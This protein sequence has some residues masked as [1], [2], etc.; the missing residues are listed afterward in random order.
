MKVSYKWLGEQVDLANVTPEELANKLTF[1]GI[2]VES[3]E[4]MSTATGLVIGE[5]ASCEKHPDSDHLHVLLVDEGE[6]YGT[7]QIVCGAPNA[8][9][10]LKVIVARPGAVLP[11][12]TIKE[13]VIRG[14]ESKGMCCSLL[15]LGVEKKHLSEKQIQGIEELSDEAKVGD[16]DVLAYLGLDDA[17][18]DLK[19]LAN[20]SDLYS[21][22]S[23]AKEVST[24]LNRPVREQAYE[25]LTGEKPTISPSSKTELSKKFCLFEAERL[26]I[27]ESPKWLRERLLSS[28]VKSINNIVDIGNYVMLLTG[29]PLNMYDR[30]KLNGKSLDVIDDYEGP[31]SAMDGN[32]YELRKGD[33]LIVSGDEPSCLAGILT[34]EKAMVTEKT[35]NIVVE[36]ASFD[37]PSIRHTASRLG[38]SS[39]SSARFIKGVN[40]KGQEHALE[41]AASLIRE[42]AAPS[43][44][45]NVSSYD[46]LER[47]ETVI[48]FAISYING[49]LGTSFTEEEIVKTLENDHLVIEKGEEGL[50][51][52]VPFYRVDIQGKADLS[53]EVIR[54]LGLDHVVANKDIPLGHGGFTKA[55]E[56]VIAI[57]RH[58]RAVGLDECLTYSLVNKET[59]NGFRYFGNGE[60]YVLLNPLTEDRSYYRGDLLPSLL[61]SLAFRYAHKELD[62][63]MFEVSEVMD[64]KGPSLRLSIALSGF[65]KRRGYLKK[66]PFDFYDLKG[67]LDGILSLLS[68]N[69]ERF[70]LERLNSLREE[71][72]PG[73]SASISLGKKAV[74]VFGELHPE[75][76]RKWKLPKGTLGL[77]LNLTELLSVQNGTPKAHFP[78]RFPIVERD[79]SF[80]IDKDVPYAELKKELKK[81][82]SLIKEAAIFDLFTAHVLGD[83]KKAVAVRLFL[84]DEKT[85]VEE[86]VVEAT[87]KAINAIVNKFK[88]E[89]RG[90]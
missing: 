32:E 53:E 4:K 68:L 79:I 88:A 87:N 58:L 82:S 13:G 55:Q 20:R 72:H 38:L 80:L 8:R 66:E 37:G 86:E 64:K 48:P 41:V 83:D 43:K 17:I 74:A 73:R 90:A 29:Q 44:I 60:P 54:L 47:K 28:G 31:F 85:L 76:I 56:D 2:E 16:E 46:V 59:F 61:S 5:I 14:V 11:G 67:L 69:P 34:S 22:E 1:A 15:E 81:S 35:R 62:N 21:L 42:L 39:D 36:A 6:K 49:R 9:K 18:L 89:V 30:D 19:I 71:F 78:S 52:Y 33:L 77:E 51:A 45:S 10:G 12:M 84:M 27:K 25:S 40:N 63:M 57:R 65:N 7:V 50:L 3:I 70:R 75:L 24:L 26:T 23:L